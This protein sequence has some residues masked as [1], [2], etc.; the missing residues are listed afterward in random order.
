MESDTY[1]DTLPSVDQDLT[2]QRISLGIH[3][4]PELKRDEKLNY[5]GEF[6]ERIIRR[7]TKKQVADIFVYTEIEEALKHEKSSKMLINGTLSPQLIDKYIKL[8]RQVDK[9]YTMI[10]DP[11]LTGNTGLVVVS[12]EAVDIKDIDVQPQDPGSKDQLSR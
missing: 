11:Q 1:N 5:L 2:L 10:Y 7:L 8:A 3:G 4:A 12:N 6:R 9:S